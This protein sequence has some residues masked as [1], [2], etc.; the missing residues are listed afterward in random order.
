[1]KEIKGGSD[2]G[3]AVETVAQRD[4]DK[5]RLTGDK[6]FASNAGAELAVVGAHCEGAPQN[7]RG[8]SLLLVP[9]RDEDGQLNYLIRRLKD[10][11]ATRS[12]PTGEIEFRHSEGWLLGQYG[13]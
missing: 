6:Y 7:V 2:L 4:G 3:R 11:I 8:L 1:M 12:V 13:T 10:K 9:R 5:W